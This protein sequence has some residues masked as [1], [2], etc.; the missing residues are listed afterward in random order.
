MASRRKFLAAGLLAAGVASASPPRVFAAARAASGRDEKLHAIARRQLERLGD[1]IWLKDMVAIVDFGLHSREKRIHFIDMEAGN[2]RSFHVTHGQGSDPDNTGW[3]EGW[4][5]VP[6][7]LA[8]SRG[9]YRT[10]NWYVGKYGK[11]MRLDGLDPS[12]DNALSRAIVMHQADYAS[13]QVVDKYG[14]L[15]RSNGCFAMAPGEFDYALERLHNGRLLFA[16]S[17]GIDAKGEIVET[18]PQYDL[19]PLQPENPD[20][21]QRTNPGV[22]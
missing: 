13:S 1:E 16:E 4:S 15:G 12:N 18:P 10:R 3:L 22:Y 21:F 20:T 11:S 14:K 2:V 8:S 7:S 17:L 6:N 9:A 19:M 5:N